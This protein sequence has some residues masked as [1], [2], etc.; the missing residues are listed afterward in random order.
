[1]LTDNSATE[2]GPIYQ[3]GP[4]KGAF[5]KD[6]LRN[7]FIKKFNTDLRHTKRDYDKDFL[8][9]YIFSSK[10]NSWSGPAMKL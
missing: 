9:W 3:K 10:P 8:K 7:L 4:E 5:L 6:V 2:F 1:M